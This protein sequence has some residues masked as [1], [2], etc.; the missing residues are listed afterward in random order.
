[1]PPVISD[2]KSFETYVQYVYQTLLNLRGEGIQVAHR[3]KLRGRCGTWYEIDVYYE[4][5]KAGVTHRVA[6]ECKHWSRPVDRDAV[7]AFHGK[8]HDIGNI[9][10]VMVSKA[11][12]Q[13]GTREFAAGY[14]I[15]LRTLEDLP[16]F[17]H[18][19]AMQVAAVALPHPDKRGEPFWT[20][21]DESGSYWSQLGPDGVTVIPLFISKPDAVAIRSKLA[22]P[23]WVVSGLPINSLYMLA[24]DSIYF[25][26]PHSAVVF[27]DEGLS[28]VHTG[29]DIRRKFL[30]PV[31]ST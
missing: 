14:G 4:F 11:G 27:S 10:G 7:C 20:I 24:S 8:L 1:M 6:F 15:D 26:R 29:E 30:E 18:V 28:V 23:A 31:S 21:M 19:V 12:F 16:E 3:S 9:H 22:D 5:E 2:A 17:H 13:S 25:G